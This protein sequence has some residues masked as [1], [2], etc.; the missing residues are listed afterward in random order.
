MI[1]PPAA[2]HHFFPRRLM[3][4]WLGEDTADDILAYAARHEASFEPSTVRRKHGPPGLSENRISLVTSD[5]GAF[6]DL[7]R[8]RALAM[9]PRLS[10]EFGTGRF[11]PDFVELE[12]VAHGDGAVFSDTAIGPGVT[13][14][15]RQISMVYYLHSRPKRFTGGQLR[16][17]AMGQSAFLDIEPEHDSLLA[18]PSMAPHAVE[19]VSCP[20]VPFADWRFA[21]N[22]WLHGKS[23][24]QSP[25]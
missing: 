11:T 2:A 18:F 15:P 23:A 1:H 7:L 17:Y 6:S 25:Y 16:Y 10:E 13:T 20:G 4:G 3:P 12:L 21:V 24:V 19:R 8:T 9:A 22:I 5:L 14:S